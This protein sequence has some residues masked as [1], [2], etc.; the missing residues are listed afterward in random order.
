VFITLIGH[1]S[2]AGGPREFNLPGPTWRGRL[3]RAAEKLPT[4]QIVF[5][6]TASC[7]RP[8]V[9]ELSGRAGRSSRR[10]AAGG[11]VRHVVRRLFRR[12]ADARAA[13]ADKN[14]R[15]SVLEAFNYAKAKSHALRA[16]RGCCRPSTRCSTITATR[17]AART[18][19]RRQGRQ[20]EHRRQVASSSRSVGRRCGLPS[21]RSCA[22]CTWSGATLERRVA[23][24]RL[25]K[26]SMT[27]AKYQSELEGWRTAIA[28]KTR[29]IRTLENRN[30]E[31]P[32]PIPTPKRQRALLGVG[33]GSWEFEL[34]VEADLRSAGSKGPDDRGT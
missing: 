5:V 15:V 24:L 16:R 3:Q 1:G 27:P 7:E 34:G 21:I 29:E 18:G 23:A 13:D 17:K 14:K 20:G 2:F 8:F 33:S 32:N 9:E 28:L 25:L 6:N 22:R 12:R 31:L 26:D 4:K 19:D 11:A 10:R 30:P